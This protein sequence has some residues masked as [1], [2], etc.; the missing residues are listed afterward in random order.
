MLTEAV[1][2]PCYFGLSQQYSRT[3]A[4]NQRKP[5][6]LV[7]KGDVSD[8]LKI[9]STVAGM[10]GPPGFELEP[11]SGRERSRGPR[12]ALLRDGVEK[13]ESA[14]EI[15]SEARDRLLTWWARLDLNQEP[16]DYESAALTVEL[17][18]HVSYLTH[19]LESPIP[20]AQILNCLR[21]E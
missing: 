6:H 10:V 13:R 17:R 4:R 1:P 8:S 20:L 19:L 21:A 5:K 12:H 15:P 7:Y 11:F 9:L 2:R 3:K 14:G 18:A 16:T